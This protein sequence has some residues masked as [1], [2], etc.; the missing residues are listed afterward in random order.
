[1]IYEIRNPDFSNKIPSIKKKLLNEDIV[2][3]IKK[4]CFKV[5]EL[6]GIID[7]V[8]TP[9]V[10]QTKRI[11]KTKQ[12]LSKTYT[13]DITYGD[14]E[15][16]KLYSIDIIIPIAEKQTTE[17]LINGVWRQPL[18]QLIDVFTITKKS[19]LFIGTVFSIRFSF[20]KGFI[21]IGK[22][23]THVGNLLSYELGLEGF[24]EKC[25]HKVKEYKK[26]TKKTN[27]TI[28]DFIEVE[29]LPGSKD[30]DLLMENFLNQKIDLKKE[31]F[32][33]E[34]FWY[35]MCKS[36]GYKKINIHDYIQTSN[37]IDLHH[38]NDKK[39]MVLR[40]FDMI[41]TD[42]FHESYNKMDVSN[43]RLYLIE[44][45][46][47]PLFSEL[48]TF[49][50]YKDS[51][52]QDKSRIINLTSNLVSN[53]PEMMHLS[54]YEG[55]MM[56]LISETYK[57]TFSGPQGLKKNSMPTDLRNIH[58]SYFGRI[59]PIYTPDREQ[60]GI[61]NYLTINSNFFKEDE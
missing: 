34:K 61:I 40:M 32:N 37:I 56:H 22:N 6:P 30:F 3:Y 59:D 24:L 44:Y 19:L 12:T 43:K 4:I 26:P 41:Y 38:K 14:K 58:S 1:M 42:K 16:T 10:A 25:H 33:S 31:K 51:S 60:T 50:M 15:N 53:A 45:I 49:Y 29:A 35:N 55:N 39:S 5:K 52:K 21:S 11:Y 36:Y 23:F 13:L 2:N 17:F 47:A 20:V 27:L 57:I 18:F 46:L 9:K 28:S 54:S 48:I 7:C 8:L